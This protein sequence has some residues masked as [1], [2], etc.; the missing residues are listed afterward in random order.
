MYVSMYFTFVFFLQF[1]VGRIKLPQH[2]QYPVSQRPLVRI[3]VILCLGFQQ[4]RRIH[5]LVSDP[6]QVFGRRVLQPAQCGVPRACFKPE[7]ML[8]R[9]R[10]QV[11][12]NCVLAGPCS[13][14]GSARKVTRIGF[15]ERVGI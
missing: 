13:S 9:Y 11:S 12:R 8:N 14:S 3:E 2:C 15:R 10:K 5:G 1:V 7:C 4:G 6:D